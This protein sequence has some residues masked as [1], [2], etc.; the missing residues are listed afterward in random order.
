MKISKIQ[1]LIINDIY[2][3]ILSKV[4]IVWYHS[5]V[6]NYTSI[7]HFNLSVIDPS[8]VRKANLGEFFLQLYL[9]FFHLFKLSYSAYWAL[10]SSEKTM[11][12]LVLNVKLLCT[13]VLYV[14]EYL[15]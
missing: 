3:A 2:V 9:D 10:K 4:S 14:L 5:K 15:L 8:S 1:K 6:E 12:Q 7:F 13:E 11:S